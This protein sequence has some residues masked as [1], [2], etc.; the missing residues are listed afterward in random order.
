MDSSMTGHRVIMEE[1]GRVEVTGVLDLLI[2][3]ENEIVL[4]TSQGVLS[5]RGMDLHMSNLS[6]DKGQIALEGDIGEIFYDDSQK[7]APK[8]KGGGLMNKLFKGLERV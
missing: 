2:F 6:L 3:D 4:D 5:I 7:A 1:R 8:G